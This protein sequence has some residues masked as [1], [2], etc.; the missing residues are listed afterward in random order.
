MTEILILYLN[1]KTK[2]TFSMTSTSLRMLRWQIES[3][4][5]LNDI[6]LEIFFVIF[7]KYGY[8]I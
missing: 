5:M 8:F 7:F 1:E 2:H 3:L 6:F 4:I